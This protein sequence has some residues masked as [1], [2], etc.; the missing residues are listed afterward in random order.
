MHPLYEKLVRKVT[1][2]WYRAGMLQSEG[3]AL[4][5]PMAPIHLH[6][7]FILRYH[8]YHFI[9][10]QQ[11]RRDFIFNS[12]GV[13]I[14]YYKDSGDYENLLYPAYWGMIHI[15]TYENGNTGGDIKATILKMADYLIA[16]GREDG[17]LMFFDYPIAHPKAFVAAPW[18]SGL[19]Q[20]LAASFLLRAHL[21][22][23]NEDYKL[24]AWRC[25][26]VLVLP[27]A[28]GGVLYQIDGRYPW[29]EEY[30]GSLP[31]TS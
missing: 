20:A 22:S 15:N 30:P 31:L 24:A 25:A 10:A 26:K 21:I 28:S 2:V 9:R 1:E 6:G 11:I 17:D 16:Q 3:Q 19:T 13:P 18:V 14:R 7:K 8:P 4:A 27:I 5:V 12:A 29:V 23:G